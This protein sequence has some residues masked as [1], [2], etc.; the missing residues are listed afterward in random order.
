MARSGDTIENPITGERIV[1]RQTSAETGGALLQCD[2]FVKPR[3]FVP[4]EHIHPRQEERFQILK[5]RMRVLLNGEERFFEQGELV[6]VPP[7]SRHQWWNP[8]EEELHAVVEFRPA[9]QSD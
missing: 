8:A 5:G 2:L 7:G 9:L 3:G 1:F 6:V 4:I